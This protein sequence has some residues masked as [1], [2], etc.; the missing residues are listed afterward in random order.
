[1]DDHT[2][3]IRSD[4][5]QFPLDIRKGEDV[6]ALKVIGEVVWSGHTFG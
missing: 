5:P 2:L 1:M 4:N 3:I 6:N